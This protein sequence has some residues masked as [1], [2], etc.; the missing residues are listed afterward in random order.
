[1]IQ[2]QY[3]RR[4]LNINLTQAYP[5]L[6]LPAV[7]LHQVKQEIMTPLNFNLRRFRPTTRRQLIEMIIAAIITLILA[8]LLGGIVW[9]KGLH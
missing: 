5:Q 3:K 1:M 2:S 6:N 9:F 4:L 8:L 7:P